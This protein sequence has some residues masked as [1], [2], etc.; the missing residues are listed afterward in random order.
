MNTISNL[1]FYFKLLESLKNFTKVSIRPQSR[2]LE[3]YIL[4]FWTHVYRFR[5][6][7]PLV[8]GEQMLN[9]LIVSVQVHPQKN[10]EFHVGLVS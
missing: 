8:N 7:W 1:S 3:K 4:A 6:Q 5:Q 10:K 2:T 9:Q